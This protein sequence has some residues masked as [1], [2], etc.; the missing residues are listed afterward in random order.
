MV[1]ARPS[2]D[3]VEVERQ[4]PSDDEIHAAARSSD[5]GGKVW[6]AMTRSCDNSGETR[7]KGK[8]TTVASRL[9]SN[10]SEASHRRWH[11]FPPSSS[12]VPEQIFY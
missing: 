12:S 10:G 1:A 8:L 2:D 7:S 9:G 4:G 6:A 5:K 3:G 11:R